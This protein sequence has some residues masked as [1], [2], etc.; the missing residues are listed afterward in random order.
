M[1]K[2][3]ILL[4]MGLVSL[5]SYSQEFR[6]GIMAGLLV[7]H[8]KNYNSRIGFDVGVKGEYT[9]TQKNNDWGMNVALMLT[10][11][12][13]KDNATYISEAGDDEHDWVCKYYS[14]ELPINAKYT[15][16]LSDCSKKTALQS[17]QCRPRLIY[18]SLRLYGH[19]YN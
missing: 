11:K 9:F 5:N 1:R 4:L 19:F 18:K 6:Y 12:G 17:L 10:S 16:H 7:S 13:W 14:L 15:Y 2:F 3:I 8:P